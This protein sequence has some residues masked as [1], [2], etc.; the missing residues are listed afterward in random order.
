MF[1]EVSDEDCEKS[2]ENHTIIKKET[3]RRANTS[4]PSQAIAAISGPSPVHFPPIMSQALAIRPPIRPNVTN[5]WPIGSPVPIGLPRTSLPFVTPP[6]LQFSQNITCPTCNQVF[7]T[8]DDLKRHLP[9][10]GIE[11]FPCHQCEKTFT[12]KTMLRQHVKVVHAVFKYTCHLCE[13]RLSTRQR[14]RGHYLSQHGTD[15]VPL[16]N[17]TLTAA[18]KL[19]FLPP[20]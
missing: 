15:N 2:E 14:L 7:M 19:T 18:E 11:M 13:R 10:H 8:R 16:E 9:D 4:P 1:A 3:A 5:P 6:H 17:V 20:E 12:S